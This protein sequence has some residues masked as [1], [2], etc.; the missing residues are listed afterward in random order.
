MPKTI[1]RLVPAPADFDL[2]RTL[3]PLR[4]G[5]RNP[6]VRFEA[7]EVWRAARTP[8]GAVTLQLLREAH[9]VRARA[10]G[11]G[12]K[13]MVRA[14]PELLGLHDAPES[15]RPSH[16]VL[17]QL[18][19]RYAGLRI[20][21][22]S[23]VVEAMVPTILKQK[24][25]SVEAARSYRALMIDLGEPAPGPPGLVLPPRAQDLAALPYWRFHPLGIER[26]RAETIRRVCAEG[27][28]L[29]SLGTRPSP[30]GQELLKTIPGGPHRL[31]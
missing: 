25:T 1:E 11:D 7:K 28:R 5:P 10:W 26:K 13:W 17:R 20:C 9:G 14:T 2:P 24:V 29:D 19:R 22:T 18:H 31:G 30:E 4:H 3:A 6:S 12:A 21:R 8:E 27:R 15:F 16:P 23:M